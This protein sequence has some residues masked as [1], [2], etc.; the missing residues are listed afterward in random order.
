MSDVYFDVYIELTLQSL[1]DEMFDNESTTTEDPV[2]LD[3]RENRIRG[4]LP[5]N[6]QFSPVESCIS[7]IVEEGTC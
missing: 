6:M 3:I 7:A 5:L 1:Q 4:F 2:R